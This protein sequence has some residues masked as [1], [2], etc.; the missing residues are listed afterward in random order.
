[1]LAYLFAAIAIAG[2]AIHLAVRRRS[3]D[4]PRAIEIF[5]AWGLAVLIGLNGV[6]GAAFHIFMADY[7]ARLIGWPTGS[8]F[9]FE[10]AMGDLA[11]GVLGVLCIWIRGRFWL[12]TI[13]A[14]S[15]QLLGDAYGHV[16][17]LVAHNDHAPYNLGPILYSDI[18]FPVAVIALYVAHGWLTRRSTEHADE[19]RSAAPAATIGAR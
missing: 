4:A 10:N 6:V 12:A 9:Q 17:Q 18:L 7:T 19:H 15:I 3:L 2:S 5:L 13:I 11:M 14:S 16:Y 8:P 1:M